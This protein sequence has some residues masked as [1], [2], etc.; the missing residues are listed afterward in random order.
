MASYYEIRGSN[1]RLVVSKGGFAT[2]Q[3]ATIAGGA[4]A[5]QLTNSVGYPGGSEIF[6]VMAGQRE[7]KPAGDKEAF[8]QELQ[9]KRELVAG[10]MTKLDPSKKEYA[11]EKGQLDDLDKAIRKLGS[12]LGRQHG[13]RF[14]SMD[15][16]GK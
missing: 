6:S 12:E 3:G 4:Y 13:V 14:S 8:L 16:A 5:K 11:W 7:E 15:Q 9:G 2:E 1:N 10:R